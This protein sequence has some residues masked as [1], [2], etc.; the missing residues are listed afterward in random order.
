MSVHEVEAAC[1]G[2]DIG[3]PPFGHAGEMELQELLV[4]E[5][6]QTLVRPLRDRLKD[7]CDKCLLEDGFEGNAQSFRILAIL[8]VHRD[9]G[10][11]PPR[12]CTSR[13]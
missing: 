3:H 6:H 8:A 10:L 13:T 9:S 5:K 4:C 12:W 7:P 2:H 11:R 1:L